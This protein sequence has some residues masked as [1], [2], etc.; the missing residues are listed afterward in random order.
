MKG[1]KP[2]NLKKLSNFFVQCTN[3]IGHTLRRRNS[4]LRHVIQGMI[5]GKIEVMARRGRRRK[6]LLHD[7]KNK[8]TGN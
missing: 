4:L 2:I 1:Y 3:R 7:L 5:D 8:D 6:K